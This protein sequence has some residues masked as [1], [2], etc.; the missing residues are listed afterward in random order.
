MEVRRATFEQVQKS[1]EE[2][3]FSEDGLDKLIELEETINPKSRSE[4]FRRLAFSLLGKG[5]DYPVILYF[6]GNKYNLGSVSEFARKIAYFTDTENKKQMI[7]LKGEYREIPIKELWTAL[8]ESLYKPMDEA[9]TLALKSSAEIYRS[10]GGSAE[11]N[12]E[13]QL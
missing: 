2:L 9:L 3:I 5:L 7:K 4:F 13:I 1:Q 10:G 12:P 8:R 6:D 11:F